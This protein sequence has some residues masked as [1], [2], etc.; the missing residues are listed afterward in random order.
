MNKQFW[1][2][3]NLVGLIA[4]GASAD[5]LW[6]EQSPRSMF[7]DKKAYAVGDILTILVQENSTASKDN[8]TKTSKQSDVD[9]ALATF[10][11][12]PAGSGMLTHNGQMPALKYSAK[13]DFNGGGTIN[14][15]EQIVAKVAVK[16]VDVLPNQQLVIEGTRKTSFGGE[17]Q[18]IVLH[19][20]VR[21]EDI[22][23]NNTVFSYNVAD[24]KIT[25]INKGSVTDSQRKGW[26]TK[27]WEVLTPF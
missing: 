11:Y 24:A 22:A 2:V 23:A 5:T 20:N 27:I 7:A 15:Q 19:G 16:V 1:L 25:F 3:C 18:D 10:L 12:S 26:F 21:T 14:N 6:R 13:Q 4:A 9:A 17:S 8:S